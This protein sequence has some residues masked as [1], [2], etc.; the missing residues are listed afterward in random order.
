VFVLNVKYNHL[1]AWQNI[2]KKEKKEELRT[3]VIINITELS[4]LNKNVY[5]MAGS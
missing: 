3:N 1:R 5:D 4:M 2:F